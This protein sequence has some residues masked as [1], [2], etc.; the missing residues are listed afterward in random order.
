MLGCAGL[1][2]AGA[3]LVLFVCRQCRGA[4]DN[5]GK[6]RKFKGN[7]IH[8]LWKT[9]KQCWNF[10]QQTHTERRNDETTKYSRKRIYFGPRWNCH[11]LLLL[12]SF[13]V[14]AILTHDSQKLNESQ[15]A[16]PAASGMRPCGQHARCGMRDTRNW[17]KT[18]FIFSRLL[19]NYISHHAT[20]WGDWCNWLLF[21]FIRTSPTSD[22]VNSDLC[23]R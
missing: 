5:E 18:S 20:H 12:L 8:R 19:L 3:V 7:L 10:A 6:R 4:L 16:R 2:W 9:N 11:C 15:S 1:R 21:I 14:S 23:Y 22:D 13:Q 17:R